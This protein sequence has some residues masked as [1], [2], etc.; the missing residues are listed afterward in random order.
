MDLPGTCSGTVLR[1][2]ATNS[3]KAPRLRS[4]VTSRT[5]TADLTQIIW[6]TGMAARAMVAIL[7]V[8]R[9]NNNTLAGSV[10]HIFSDF[11]FGSRGRT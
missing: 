6:L 5:V 8:V 4:A 9:A 10:I 2:A 7:D 11:R 3:P 1:S